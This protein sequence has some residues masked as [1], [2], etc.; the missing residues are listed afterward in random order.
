[1]DGVDGGNGGNG[2]NGD[3]SNASEDVSAETFE[4]EQSAEHDTE[5]WASDTVDCTSHREDLMQ[6]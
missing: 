4:P 6:T 2:G 1:V 5:W 3:W